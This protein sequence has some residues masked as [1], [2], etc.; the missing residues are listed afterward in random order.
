MVTS[1]PVEL[2]DLTDRQVHLHLIGLLSRHADVLDRLDTFMADLTGSVS[3][4][5]GAVD[6]VALRWASQ[7]VPLTDALRAAQE[8]AAAAEI[9]NAE[10]QAALDSALAEAQTAADAIQSEVDELNALGA[11]PDAPVEPV[12][13]DELPPPPSE[14]Q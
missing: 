13:V 6:S 2:S 4:L 10:Q 1:I 5:Q 8:A 14:E 9:S 7:M 12:P 3:A 11:E